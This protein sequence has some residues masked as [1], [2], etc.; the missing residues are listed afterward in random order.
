MGGWQRVSIGQALAGIF[1]QTGTYSLVQIPFVTAA[2][3]WED[4]NTLRRRNKIKKI[5]FFIQGNDK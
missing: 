3:V 5:I 4:K 1:P 2:D